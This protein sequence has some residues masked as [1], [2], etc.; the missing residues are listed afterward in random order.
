MK[1]Q[2]FLSKYPL[3]TKVIKYWWLEKLM[4]SMKENSIPEEF[5]ESI[6]VEEVITDDRLAVLIEAQPRALFDVFDINE[7]YISVF[8]VENVF[9][10]SFWNKEEQTLNGKIFNTRKDAEIFVI[11]KGFEVLENKLN[12]IELPK[13][14][15]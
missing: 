14:E 11:E 3:T 10:T 5:K 12:S 4:V 2:E 9:M 6:L 8:R 15:E 1:T 7:I 13:L